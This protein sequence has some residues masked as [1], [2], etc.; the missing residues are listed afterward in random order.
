MHSLSSALFGSTLRRWST[1]V[2]SNL[3]FYL[4]GGALQHYVL[5]VSASPGLALV[6]VFVWVLAGVLNG[7]IMTI[8]LGDLIVYDGF[9]DDVLRDEMAELDAKI[10]G[11]VPD[12]EDED[13]DALVRVDDAPAR[14]H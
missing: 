4:G 10:M 9:L 13:I 6:L 11:D 5:E 14:R 8:T 3:I 7:L 12:T 2:I 1:C